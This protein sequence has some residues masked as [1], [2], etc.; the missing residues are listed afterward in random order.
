MLAG[1]ALQSDGV[2]TPTTITLFA[3]E[4]VTRAVVPSGVSAND[5][6]SAPRGIARTT[7]RVATSMT[8]SDW[9][10]YTGTR[11]VLPS[12]VIVTARGSDAPSWIGPMTDRDGT[13]RAITIVLPSK[14]TKA[15]LPS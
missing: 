12:G 9:F 1:P 7:V 14:A 5:R 8:S 6:G 13:S 11:A 4:D 15:V 3:L 2:A 10:P